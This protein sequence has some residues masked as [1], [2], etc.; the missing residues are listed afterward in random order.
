MAYAEG[1]ARSEI[2]VKCDSD[3]IINSLFFNVN[4]GIRSDNASPSESVL[5]VI[6]DVEIKQL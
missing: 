5:S 2:A 1:G 4:S 3:I 6:R